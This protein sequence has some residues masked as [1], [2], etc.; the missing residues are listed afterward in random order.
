MGHG[1]T[2]KMLDI[3]RSDKLISLKHI[4]KELVRLEYENI[5]FYDNYFPLNNF[6]T[7]IQKHLDKRGTR[8]T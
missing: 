5:K 7:V 3:Y 6:N 4:K 2:E 8:N 1:G